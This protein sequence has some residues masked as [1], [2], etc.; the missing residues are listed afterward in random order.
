MSIPKLGHPLPVIAKAPETHTRDG[1][2]AYLRQ[3]GFFHAL[4]KDAPSF[5]VKRGGDGSA[6]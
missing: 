1:R 4:E 3:G 5:A 6:G 2:R